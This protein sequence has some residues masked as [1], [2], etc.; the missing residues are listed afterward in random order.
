MILIFQ[1]LELHLLNYKKRMLEYLTFFCSRKPNLFGQEPQL[2]MF[3]KPNVEVGYNDVPI[4]SDMIT[5][6][7][8]DFVE[9][10]R[11]VESADYCKTLTGIEAN[12]LYE[13][14]TLDNLF[15]AVCLSLD[16]TFKSA[17]KAVVVEKDKSHTKLM[18]GGILSTLNESN[19]I[20]SWVCFSITPMG[21]QLKKNHE[22]RYCQTQSA[23]EI[24]EI[25]TGI[26]KRCKELEVAVP[27]MLVVDNCCH[28]RG[29]V[30]QALPHIRVLFDVYHFMMRF[31]GS[32]MFYEK[33][34]TSFKDIWLR[35][36]MVLRIRIDPK[37]HKTFVMQF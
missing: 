27:E 36:S 9:Q 3:S 7:Y 25:L 23:A 11:Q 22:Q 1:Q 26:A 37:S 35:S 16:N 8:L 34:L 12:P 31:E 24:R 29:N 20:L 14:Q 30:T 18:K 13:I 5:D 17:G 28:V 2:T 21:C 32:L 19:E 15:L 10:T 33:K 6:V 4:T